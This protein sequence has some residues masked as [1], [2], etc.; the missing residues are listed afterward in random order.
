VVAR[1]T[2]TNYRDM[3]RLARTDKSWGR[4]SGSGGGRAQRFLLAQAGSADEGF[5]RAAQADEWAERPARRAAIALPDFLSPSERAALAL[6]D[7]LSPPQRAAVALRDFL[8]PPQG[9]AVA[10]RDFLSSSRRAAAAL[11]EAEPAKA[12]ARTADGWAERALQ[13]AHR[14]MKRAISEIQCSRSQT[15]GRKARR[16]GPGE[17]VRGESL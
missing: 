10:L 1:S 17:P 2:L 3:Q 15:V 16:L 8:S 6:P 14:A 11:R 4:T 5:F 12:R 13:W 9:A 7:F